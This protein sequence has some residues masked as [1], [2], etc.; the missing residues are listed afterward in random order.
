MAQHKSAIDP[1]ASMQAVESNALDQIATDIR[2]MLIQPAK[3][4]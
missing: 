3:A 2:A 1:M 4:A